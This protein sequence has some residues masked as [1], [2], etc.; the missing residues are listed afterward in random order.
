[1]G[2]FAPFGSMPAIAISKR[3]PERLR[4]IA[5]ALWLLAEFLVERKRTGGM[6]E[7]SFIVI[8]GVQGG[9]GALRD[10]PAYTR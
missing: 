3:L 2:G 6:S 8:L 4:R 10:R 5:S 9:Q 1:V 7:L